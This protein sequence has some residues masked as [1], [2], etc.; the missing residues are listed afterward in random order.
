MQTPSKS[1][2]FVLRCREGTNPIYQIFSTL[3]DPP[4]AQLT[5]KH[6]KDPR[7]AA[8]WWLLGHWF[9]M[10]ASPS[11]HI[12]VGALK[13]RA[14][15]LGRRCGQDKLC[16]AGAEKRRSRSNRIWRYL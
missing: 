2:Y 11:P 1:D 12:G 14:A 6:P 16:F 15:P 5:A 8:P 4:G 9:T 3:A 13:H 7:L 10:G